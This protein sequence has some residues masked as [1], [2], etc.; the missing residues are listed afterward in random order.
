MHGTLSTKLNEVCVY[1]IIVT[2]IQSD[3][4][5]RLRDIKLIQG[6]NHFNL[7]SS[8]LIKVIIDDHHKIIRPGKGKLR[9]SICPNYE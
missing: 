2:L 4:N 3:H 6:M 5:V 7:I 8:E 1:S 9:G